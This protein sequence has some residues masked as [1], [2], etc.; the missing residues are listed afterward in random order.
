MRVCAV[1][2]LAARHA[3]HPS[4]VAL[5]VLLGAHRLLAVAPT[6]VAGEGGG[7][8]GGGGSHDAG[9]ERVRVL[10]RNLLPRLLDQTCVLGNVETLPALAPPLAVHV[11]TETLAVPAGERRRMGGVRKEGRKEGRKEATALPLLGLTA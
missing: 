6:L 10:G 9:M 4:L 8:G 2:A 7:E 11:G 5:A 3:P 1:V